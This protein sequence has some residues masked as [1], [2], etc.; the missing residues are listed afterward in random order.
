M[1]GDDM[2]IKVQ[3]TGYPYMKNGIIL[4]ADLTHPVIRYAK[5]YNIGNKRFSLCIISDETD[6]KTMEHWLDAQSLE[7]EAADIRSAWQMTEIYYVKS[8]KATK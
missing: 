7:M 3:A 8:S 6:T 1:R 5:N 2:S 4:K